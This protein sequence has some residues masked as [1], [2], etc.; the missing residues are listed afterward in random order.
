MKGMMLLVS[1][2]LG[3]N[4][5]AQSIK[6][7]LDLAIEK[8]EADSQMRHGLVAFCVADGKTGQILY[9]HHSQIGMA[10]ASCQK[11]F[12]SIAAFE[13]LGADYRYKTELGIDGNIQMGILN[14][15]LHLTGSGDP[16]LG[17]WRWAE[18]KEEPFFGIILASLQQNHI[19]KIAGRIL[20]D[21]SKF[22]IQG[23]PDGWIWQDIGNYYG[24]GCWGI[25]WHENQYDMIFQPGMRIGDPARII[26]LKPQIDVKTFINQVKTGEQGSGDNGYIY[27]APY[28]TGG[29]T[30]GTIPMGEKTFTISGSLPY[31]SIEMGRSLEK[32]LIRNNIQVVKGFQAYS[33]Q[34]EIGQHWPKQ[35]KTILVHYSPPLDSMNYWFLKKSIN[36]YAEALVKTI[37][38][39]KTGSGTTEKGLEL[40]KKYW[41]DQGIELSAIN[42]IDGSGLSPQNRITADALVKALY[43]ANAHPWFSSFYNSLPE[44]NGMKMKSGSIGGVKSFAGYQTGSDG[45]QY[46]FA[47]IVNNYDGNNSSMI[48]KIFGLLDILK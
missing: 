18:T 32:A 39:V 30:L 43:K 17:S 14:G 15:N 6:E 47:V 42:M 29:F 20:L 8:M 38:Y 19:N 48:E 36:L 40:I 34:L 33:E 2:F 28:A 16:T 3:G 25:N 22:D 7:K 41:N 4:N 23:V 35:Q 11:I 46:I 12:T 27:L 5:I 45:N 24:A 26:G 31:P 1:L 10:P 13:L 21:D 44:I 37:A 9:D